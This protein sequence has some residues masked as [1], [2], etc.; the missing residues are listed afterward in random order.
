MDLIETKGEIIQNFTGISNADGC[1]DKCNKNSNCSVWTFMDGVCYMKNEKTFLIRTTS[2]RLFS[3]MKDCDGTGKICS[4]T[5]FYQI[6]PMIWFTYTTCTQSYTLD[7]VMPGVDMYGG[8]TD[9]IPANNYE[10]CRKLCTKMSHCKRWTYQTPADGACYLKKAMDDNE[11]KPFVANED[12]EL[13]FKCKTGFQNSKKVK[14][15]EIGKN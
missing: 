4:F 9:A 2:D 1:T 14:C 8:D 13:C 7:C 12:V 10:E 6:K 15:S 5:Y 3:G 11:G